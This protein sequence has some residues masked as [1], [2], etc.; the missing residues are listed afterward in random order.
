[1]VFVTGGTGL[2]GSHLLVELTQQH[3]AITAIY[4]NETKISTV[5]ECFR[6]YLRDKADTCFSK[7]IWK[8]CD[9]MDVPFLE[10]AMKNHK[11]IYHCAGMVSYNR[12]DF[13]Q[14]MD[15]NRYGTANMVNIALSLDV[16]QFCYVSSSAAVGNK[17]IPSEVEVDEDGKWVLDEETSGYSISKYS[18]EKEV[19]RG[20]NE[21][22]NAVIVNPTVII[23]AGSWKE[24]SMKIVNTIRK[25][26]KYYTPGENAFVDARDVAQIMVELV[27]RKISNERFLCT[28]ENASFK[29]LF[30]VVAKELGKKPPSVKVPYKLMK[31]IWRLSSL[32]AVLT[33]SKAKIT[34]AVVRNAYS[35]IK[36]SNKKL[37]NSLGY[38][39][40]PLEEMIRNAVKGR[41]D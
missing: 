36:F 22:L 10:E 32:W 18:A 25:Q 28:G 1:M 33:F 24:S 30:E 41:L 11:I 5:K 12:N 4:R 34:H 7:I 6:Y 39:F 8:K 21:G 15:I 16:Q 19:W 13:S 14:M 31:F 37:K 40:R 29:Y 3:N 2:L 38:T 35:T 23:G 9:I 17:E 27:R 26:S 20:I